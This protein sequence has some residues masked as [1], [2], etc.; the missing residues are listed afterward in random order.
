ARVGHDQRVATE[1]LGDAFLEEDDVERLAGNQH[2][3]RLLQLHLE[4]V[5]RQAEHGTGGVADV[6]EGLDVGAAGADAHELGPRAASAAREAELRL[7]AIGFSAADA[8]ALALADR[9][10]A[11]AADP[12]SG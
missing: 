2:L 5:K 10:P 4:Q 8:R 7:R 12:R 9:L 11:A 3:H 6:G 1:W